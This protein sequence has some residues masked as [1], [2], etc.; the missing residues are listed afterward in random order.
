MTS[1]ASHDSVDPTAG[2]QRR[3]DELEHWL[4]DLRVNLSEDS[5]AW[6]RPAGDAEQRASESPIVPLLAGNHTRREPGTT[7][8]STNPGRSPEGDPPRPA[9]G[10]HRAPD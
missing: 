4:T 9:P 7:A 1:T 8:G 6:L 5:Q 10:R 2:Q 3:P